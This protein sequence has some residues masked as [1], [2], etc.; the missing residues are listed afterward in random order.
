M[1][2]YV[3]LYVALHVA[4]SV[5][6][7]VSVY[8]PVSVSVS[9]SVYVS[10]HATSWPCYLPHVVGMWPAGVHAHKESLLQLLRHYIRARTHTHTLSH[11]HTLT[12]SLS[13][14]LTHSLSL[15]HTHTLS[16][17]LYIGGVRPAGVRTHEEGL[18]QLLLHGRRGHGHVCV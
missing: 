2:L 3:A 8:V 4:S 18:L 13:H 14:S 7:S 10:L 9:V 6:V 11:T 16:L 17:S 1:A 15:S 12:L 5:S